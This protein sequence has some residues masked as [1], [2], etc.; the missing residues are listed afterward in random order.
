MFH[1]MT[2]CPTRRLKERKDLLWFLSPPGQVEHSK[3]TN[4]GQDAEN[5]ELLPCMGLP[6]FCPCIPSGFSVCG[7]GHHPFQSVL[8]G[9]PSQTR[10]GVPS[11][12]PSLSCLL[13]R[14]SSHPL[15]HGVTLFFRTVILPSPLCFSH[16][17]AN[18]LLLSFPHSW[19]S[20]C[21]RTHLCHHRF[22]THSWSL[23]GSSEGI[24]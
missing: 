20:V 4:L 17:P 7:G 9:N 11:Q 10:G 8:S 19:S 13:H 12:S 16:T 5:L 15:H 3:W 23:L 18:P 14:E 6:P 21:F 22:G 24:Q 2:R 1:L